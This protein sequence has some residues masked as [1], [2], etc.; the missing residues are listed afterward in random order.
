MIDKKVIDDATNKKYSAFSDAI[1]VELR[2]K[3]ANH[4]VSK[5]YTSDFDKIQQMKSAF[6]KINSSEE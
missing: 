4:S 3:M 6:A 5:S 1:K 2:N